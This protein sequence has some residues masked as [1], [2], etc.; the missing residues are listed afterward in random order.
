MKKSL[1]AI[2]LLPILGWAA[3]SPFD[4]TWKIDLSSVQF[5]TQPTVLVLQNGTYQD[6]TSR[7][8]VKADGTDQ[9][10]PEIKNIDTM[11]AVPHL[12]S[13]PLPPALPG[14]TAQD[15]FGAMI[16]CLPGRRRLMHGQLK[17]LHQASFSIKLPSRRVTIGPTSNCL[18]RIAPAVDVAEALP[19]IGKTL[20]HYQITSQLGK[21]GMSEV[22]QAKDQKLCGDVAIKVL[23]K[24]FAK[25]AECSEIS[26][27]RSRVTFE[28]G[29]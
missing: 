18:H 19:M 12:Q 3:Q 21:G 17:K 28:F 25:G 8:S 2:L 4:G 10:V 9:P 13:P 5:P 6:S 26:L 24:E 14:P 11:A 1:S 7:I 20:G 23:P 22:F 16:S 15:E 29:R 27:K